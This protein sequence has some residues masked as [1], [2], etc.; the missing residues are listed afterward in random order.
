[1]P[2]LSPSLEH[3]KQVLTNRIPSP[4]RLYVEVYAILLKRGL[5]G[6]DAGGKLKMIGI[7]G[8]PR[9]VPEGAEIGYGLH[10]DYWGKR[11]MTEAL[12][13]FLGIYWGPGSAFP[14]LHSMHD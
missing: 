9:S 10:P 4:E 13:M 11:C 2:D 8:A 5:D 6:K 1:M 7:V 14:L 12:E 3:S